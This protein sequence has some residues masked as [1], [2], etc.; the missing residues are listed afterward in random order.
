MLRLRCRLWL[1]CLFLALAVPPGLRADE[2]EDREL[3]VKQVRPLLEAHCLKCHSHAAGKSRGEL[4]LDSLAAVKKGG[5]TG[6]AVVPGQPGKS[7]LV[8]AIRYQHE[9]MKMPPGGKLTDE[10]IAVLT[11]WVERGAPWPGGETIATVRPRGQI[12]AADRKFWAFQP[13]NVTPPPANRETAHPIDRFLLRPL[14]AAGLKFAPVAERAALLRR[15]TFDMHGL[16]PS[17]EEIDAFVKDAAPNAWEKV[18]DRL[19]ASPRYGERWARHWLDLVRYAESDGFRLDEYRP[20]AWRYRDYVIAAFNKDKP[21]D[22]FLREQLA[23]D[24]L[25]PDDPE[26]LLATSFLRLG[27][28]EYNS[29]DVRG[30]HDDM[31]NEITDVVGDAFLGMSVACARCHDHKFDPI[32]QKDYYRLRAFFATLQPYDEVPLV[33]PKERTVHQAKMEFW[34]KKTTDIRARIEAMEAPV[35]VKAA[36]GA[37]AK[38]PEDIQV[39]IRMPAAKRTPLEKQLVALAYR[40]VQF[41]F[42]RLDGR[43]KDDEKK[44]LRQLRKELAAFDADKPAPLPLG[45][46]ARDIGTEAPP[47]LLPRSEPPLAVEPGFLSVLSEGP[48]EIEALPKL[49]STGR[50]T[51]LARWLTQPENPLTGRVFVNRVWQHHFGRGLVG[52]PNDF[53]KL[54]EQP[55]HPEL[56]DWLTARFVQDGW[57]VKKLH[58]LILTS[59]AY[60]QSAVVPT[61]PAARERDPD[62]RLLWRMTTRRL[63]AEQIRDALLF[64]TGQLDLKPGGP[65]VDPAQPRRSI[66]LKAFRNKRDPLL[67]V[68]DLPERITSTAQRSVTTSPL[69]AMLMLNGPFLQKQA[70]ALAELVQKLH[71]QS[72]EERIAAVFRRAWGREPTTEE[73]QSAADFLRRRGPTGLLDLCHVLLNANEFLYVD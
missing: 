25:A 1:P 70:Q 53:G 46:T 68:F 54:G 59:A 64:T 69:Q 27:I 60:Q 19:L 10:Q 56:L 15:V 48:V 4:M 71:P 30:Q 47:T 11:R 58:R 43:F 3:F 21:F 38:F 63:D 23:G 37:I 20:N 24:E 73:R 62:N 34:I 2:A 41:E 50:R 65:S 8:Q 22:R 16:P 40:Q 5:A 12:T 14:H 33:S 67:G 66:Y 17:P 9:K 55:T 72:E 31:L 35:R 44:K 6:P 39:M 42:E 18:V 52:T 29:R 7:L 57:S 28:Y 45:L 51:A 49:A 36:E 26:A 32:P 61:L 13:L